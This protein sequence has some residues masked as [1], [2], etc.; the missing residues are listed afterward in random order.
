[1]NLNLIINES[2]RERRKL[3][4]IQHLMEDC[5]S[6]FGAV[7]YNI[8]LVN[9]NENSYMVQNPYG[10][11]G[12][13]PIIQPDGT[14]KNDNYAYG[15]SFVHPEDRELF[16]SY[17]TLEA[18]EQKLTTEG[19]YE[20]FRIR[21]ILDNEYRWVQVNLVR[22]GADDDHFRVLYFIIDIQ[23][24]VDKEEKAK[25]IIEDALRHAHAAD[26]A[27]SAFL[28][29]MSHDI[30][31]PLNAITGMTLLARKYLTDRE[32][33]DDYLKKIDLSCKLLTDIINEV[34]D[35]SAIESGKLTLEIAPFRLK[36]IM[37]EMDAMIRP[38]AAA[39]KIDL[40]MDM[41]QTRHTYLKGD[42][43]QLFKLL[44]NLLTNAVKYTPCGGHVSLKI[45]ELEQSFSDRSMYRFTCRDDGIGMS[46]EFQKK[47]F[48]PFEREN[49]ETVQKIQGTGLG[50]NIIQKLTEAMGGEIALESTKGK[51]TVFTVTIC[52]PV[53][54]EEE[55]L[56]RLQTSEEVQQ[57]QGAENIL[58][59]CHILMVEDN[60]LNREI[61]VEILTASGAVLDTA[62]DGQEAVEKF[63]SSAKD[64]YDVI[65]MD[66]RMPNMDGYQATEMIRKQEGSYAAQIPI[67][68]MTAEAFSNEMRRAYDC[69]MNA[70]ISKPIVVEDLMQT[71]LGVMKNEPVRSA[72]GSCGVPYIRPAWV[73]EDTSE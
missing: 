61:A 40:C 28:S 18:Y 20:Y 53:M 16:W 67:I 55:D 46:E 33:L 68:A 42:P 72:G 51:G 21:H 25:E 10:D 1:M 12:A 62:S 70:Y 69:G 5:F 34:L 11:N 3:R 8:I 7:F 38:Q 50:L 30:R 41:E 57:E 17:T 71:L 73:S 52:F 23:E 35:I 58:K 24:Q 9:V 19:H 31:T 59:G 37:K 54:P 14:Y 27:K 66:I 45:E 29:S 47:A 56:P 48:M 65:L 22:L 4:E 49:D 6:G 63:R 44:S 26:E 43:V 2:Q 64:P 60:E 13:H 32:K 36:D 15:M 39:K